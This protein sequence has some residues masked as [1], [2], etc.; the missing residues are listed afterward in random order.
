MP[1]DPDL[2]SRIAA[3]VA[4]GFEDQIAFTQDLIRFPS[5]RGREHEVQGFAAQALRVV[6]YVARHGTEEG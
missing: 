4:E 2:A 6:D 5:P 3:S 1:L